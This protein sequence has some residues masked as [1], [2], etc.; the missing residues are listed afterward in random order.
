[1]PRAYW[2]PYHRYKD[3]TRTASALAVSLLV[4]I[5]P[6]CRGYVDNCEAQIAAQVR[7]EF[8]HAWIV[9]RCGGLAFRL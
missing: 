6:A 8:L 5:R 2:H 9:W 4:L 7:T 1:M 3:A